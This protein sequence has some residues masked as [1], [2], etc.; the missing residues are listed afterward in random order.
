MLRGKR[1]VLG[2]TGGIAAYKSAELTRLFVTSGANVR[3]VM[4]DHATQFIT[5]LTLA[6]LSGSPVYSDTFALTDD[7]EIG[8]ISLTESADLM[9]IAP[10]TANII[11]KI[12]SGIADDL[13]STTVMA[14]RAPILI[15][16]AM[17]TN[18]YENAIVRANMEKLSSMGYHMM[19][20]ARGELA[21][22]TEG[23]GRLQPVDAIL[24]ESLSILTPKDLKGETILITA[25]PTR[26]SIDPVRYITNYSSGKMG[27]ALARMARR[28]GA[29]V[30]LVSGPTALSVP[31]GVICIAVSSA[32]EM[33]EAV[34]KHMEDASI[35]IKAAA[36]ADYRPAQYS[37]SKIKKG[38]GK[39]SVDMEQNPDIL[40]CLGEK[41]GA[42]ILVGF[43]METEDLIANATDKM[44][45]KNTDMIV[46]NDLTVEGAGF[47]HDTNVVKILDRAGEIEECPL[48]S[49]EEV[50]MR[51][52]DR[53]RTM[54]EERNVQ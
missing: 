20:A 9:V 5:P 28:R 48:L 1:I 50:A 32:M 21:C 47:G 45:K 53:I 22:G 30:I 25:G 46:A 41:K 18:M 52:L 14:T 35:V 10:A 29:R 37:Q 26:E 2:V 11:G 34:M 4:T 19:D 7:W 23:A 31:E 24:E 16:P 27:Y 49:K 3:I 54:V 8:H 12:A 43:A 6:T 15:C 38:A 17:N 33:K 42:R 36:V 13:L 51:I 44:I 40:H 39:F